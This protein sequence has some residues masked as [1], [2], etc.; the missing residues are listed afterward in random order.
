[1][2]TGG[3]P[4]LSSNGPMQV[5]SMRSSSMSISATCAPRTQ[6]APIPRMRPTS[7]PGCLRNFTE[8]GVGECPSR[9]IWSTTEVI[10]DHGSFFRDVLTQAL[11]RLLK[12]FAP[13][14]R[15]ATFVQE[16]SPENHVNGLPQFERPVFDKRVEFLHQFSKASV[17]VAASPSSSRQTL[18]TSVFFALSLLLFCAPLFSAVHPVP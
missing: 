9:T 11:K 5:W 18:R 12:I 15:A 14:S 13:L 7:A 17:C 3:A 10:G 4:R 1:M 16:Y 6:P 8:S 2:A